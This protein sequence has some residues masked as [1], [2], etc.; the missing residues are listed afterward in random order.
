MESAKEVIERFPL[1]LLCLMAVL[2]LLESWTLS[3]P[4]SHC[5]F[6]HQ[7]LFQLTVF[8]STTCVFPSTVPVE[9]TVLQTI[10]GQV[11]QTFSQVHTATVLQQTVYSTSI[12]PVEVAGAE[13]VVPTVHTAV[14]QTSIEVVGRTIADCQCRLQC[15]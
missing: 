10:V 1:I 3:H 11:P 8:S 14:C 15:C 4:Q 13:V 7:C 9:S 6:L 12:V 5:Q 2:Q